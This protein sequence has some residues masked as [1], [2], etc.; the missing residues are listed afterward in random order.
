M[1]KWVVSAKLTDIEL[2]LQEMLDALPDGGGTVHISEGIYEISEPLRMPTNIKGNVNIRG[3]SFIGDKKE[4]RTLKPGKITFEGASPI[5]YWGKGNTW[6]RSRTEAVWFGTKAEA[7]HA[8]F[9]IVRKRPVL[10]GSVTVE[11]LP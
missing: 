1:L 4:P 11:E 9:E 3:C 6:K 2:G 5:V 8:A 7:E 10:I